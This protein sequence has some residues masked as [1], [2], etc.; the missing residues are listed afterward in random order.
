MTAPRPSVTTLELLPAYGQSENRPSRSAEALAPLDAATTNQMYFTYGLVDADGAMLG[1]AGAAIK[2]IDQQVP[3]SGF[4]TAAALG[5]VSPAYAFQYARA[6]RWRDGGDVQ[7]GAVIADHGSGGRR[8]EEFQPD[9]P[10]PCGRN[11]I[12]WLRESARL[13]ASFGTGLHCPYVFAFIGTSAK[14]QSAAD[15]RTAFNAAHA[16]LVAEVEALTGT[17]PKLVMVMNGSDVRSIGDVYATPSA[18]YRLAMEHGALMGTWQRIYPINDRNIHL[19]PQEK[20]L[21]GETCAWAAEIDEAGGPWNITYAVAKAG[22]TVTVSFDLRPGEVLLNRPDLY[23]A[24]GGPATCPNFGFEAEGGILAAIPDFGGNTVT[25]TLADPAA[26]WLR[27]AHQLQDCMD[28]VDEQGYAM[29]A[30]RSTL[31]GSET[32]P[33]RFVPGQTL[34]R[35][36]PGFRGTFSGDAFTAEGG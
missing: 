28:M 31:F 35:P 20:V 25:L 2:A 21:I 7:R 26:S 24:Y 1:P 6:A 12:Y 16:P 30:H 13:A 32:R 3:A 22:D 17:T 14:T 19:D 8:I 34:W 15:F 10:T 36:L 27:F 18:Q 33:S 23:D 11:Q 9:N 5:S 4:M 29:S